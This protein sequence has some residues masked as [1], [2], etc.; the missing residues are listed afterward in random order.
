MGGESLPLREGAAV[1]QLSNQWTDAHVIIACLTAYNNR[2]S[3]YPRI[4]QCMSE[5]GGYKPNFIALD[6]VN[7]SK[8]ANEVRDFLNFGGRLGTEQTCTSDDHCATDSCN[9]ALRLCQCQECSPNADGDCLGCDQGQYCASPGLGI[10]MCM[11]K[12]GAGGG[13]GM[14]SPDL[15]ATPSSYPSASPTAEAAPVKA[16]QYCGDAWFSTVANCNDATPCTS[17]DDCSDGQTC[18]GGVDCTKS[19]TVSPSP[20]YFPSFNN[21]ALRPVNFKPSSGGSSGPEGNTNFC[22]L[23]FFSTKLNCDVAVPCPGPDGNAK[24]AFLGE[25]YTCFSNIVCGGNKP[26]TAGVVPPLTTSPPTRKP[27]LFFPP[28]NPLSPP[29]NSKPTVDPDE[30][31]WLAQLGVTKSPVHVATSPPTR[32]PTLH[33]SVLPSISPTEGTF[34][35]SNTYYCGANY[36]YASDNCYTAATPCPTG[37]PS[38]CDEGETCY[39]GIVCNKPPS[40]SPTKSPMVWR[41]SEPTSN[42]IDWAGA[43]DKEGGD[44][45]TNGAV[46][47]ANGLLA[48]ATSIG[49]LAMI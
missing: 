33:P 1:Q 31:W 45:D 36:T 47:S 40:L 21:P 23:D 14:Q 41:N 29:P 10:N 13:A 24:C 34:D 35:F 44:T 6:W 39:G 9:T 30:S 5:N 32:S 16:T 8:E 28:T 38:A 48:F 43:W 46:M 26:T 18:F 25:E 11:D 42:A 15:T 12:A 22:G 4:Q 17:N 3:I 2:G 49:F 7:Q 20:S 27:T 37:S 19:P